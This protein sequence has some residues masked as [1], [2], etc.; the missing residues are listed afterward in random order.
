ML[1][2]VNTQHSV[3]HGTSQEASDLFNAVA[4]NCTCEMR[5]GAI[6]QKLCAAHAMI[7]DQRELDRLLFARYMAER[8][9]AKELAQHS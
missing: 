5:D 7:E 6:R 2:D 1:T 8:W 4:H 9:L 3:W